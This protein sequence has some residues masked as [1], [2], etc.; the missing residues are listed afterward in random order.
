MEW[1]KFCALLS[2]FCAVCCRDHIR[3]TEHYTLHPLAQNFLASFLFQQHSHDPIQNFLPQIFFHPFSL[4]LAVCINENGSCQR[5]PWEF[6]PAQP[7]P[8]FLAGAAVTVPIC[9][10]CNFDCLLPGHADT[11]G[12]RDKGVCELFK[13]PQLVYVQGLTVPQLVVCFL[14][15]KVL[16]SFHLELF[17]VQPEYTVDVSSAPPLKFNTV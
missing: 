14:Q 1:S 17:E 5:V 7:C 4:V 16:N 12:A 10:L 3:V 6:P 9:F 15:D 8:S 11:S 13:C 2:F